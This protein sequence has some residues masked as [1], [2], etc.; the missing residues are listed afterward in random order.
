MKNYLTDLLTNNEL[1]IS[2]ILSAITILAFWGLANFIIKKVKKNIKKQPLKQKENIVALLK[3][4]IKVLLIVIAISFIY[5]YFKERFDIEGSKMVFM[6]LVISLTWLAIAIIKSIKHFVLASYNIQDPD[7]LKARKIHTQMRVFEHLLI[8]LVVFIGLAIALL[9]IDKVREIG[10]S[11]L[12]SA[13]IAGI[14]IG[15]AAQK[16]LSLLL[17]GFQLAI[18]QPIRLDDVVIIEGEWGWIEEITLTYVVVKIWDKRR[19]VVPINYF[20]EKPFQN[21]T[22][23]T[24]EILGTVFIYVDYGFPVDEMRNE[25]ARILPNIPEW[26]GEVNVLQVTNCTEKTMELRALVSAQNSPKAWDLRVK[27]R[28][29]LIDFLQKKHPESM[30]KSRVELDKN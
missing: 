7:N 12:A 26:D 17:A 16:S 30:P 11:L 23:Q 29:A 19:L 2:I 22:R 8:F 15:F 18:T 24:S 14:I 1:W 5:A 21:W 10:I 9:S 3:T 27:L 25:M 28:E 13:G 6:L 20:I 4:P